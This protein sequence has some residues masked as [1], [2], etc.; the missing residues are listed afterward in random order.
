[1]PRVRMEGPMLK[2]WDEVNLNLKEIGECELAVEKIE[3]ALNEK[4]SDLK[5]EATDK[6][7][8]HQ[9][10]IKKLELELKEF[11]ETHRDDLG[12]KK[13]K[14]LDFGKLGFRKSTK[15]KLPRAAN[16]LAEI[17]NKL[18]V[19]GMTDCVVQPPAKVDKDSLKKYPV[20]EIVRVGAN[21]E[22]DDVFW[23]E[24]DRERLQDQG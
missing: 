18:K 23:Y 6:A 8:S 15:I 3:A 22:V 16:K 11:V 21:V 7:K 5:L 2:S 24:W 14:V 20:N 4:I 1:M 19:F 10:R 12:N 17:I 13:T 9:Q